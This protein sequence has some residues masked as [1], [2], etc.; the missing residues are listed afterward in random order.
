M[1]KVLEILGIIIGLLI[2]IDQLFKLFS[3]I[4]FKYS[5]L[6][7]SKQVIK[8]ARDV[9]RENDVLSYIKAIELNMLVMEDNEEGKI[10]NISN[11]DIKI[12]STKP[13]KGVFT[14]NDV[15]VKDG[16]F[17][18]DIEPNGKYYACYD[19]GKVTISKTLYKLNSCTELK[20][21]LKNS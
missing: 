20:E 4:S 13:T 9:V 8:E 7:V 12:S 6:N 18:Y 11:Y 17:E 2:I 16:L 5:D 15:D 1:K 10:F 21:S 19:E 3:G 14:L